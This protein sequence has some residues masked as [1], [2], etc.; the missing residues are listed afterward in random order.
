[1]RALLLTT[2]LCAAPVCAAPGALA[3]SYDDYG[4]AI[5][6]QQLGDARA[7]DAGV[8]GL[9]TGFGP[10]L[11]GSTSGQT[12]KALIDKAPLSS[13]SAVTTD[14]I[15]R[16][17]LTGGTPPQGAVDDPKYMA[18]RLGALVKLGKADEVDLIL[19]RQPQQA[20]SA[21]GRQVSADKALSA[22]DIAGACTIA[23][24][25]TE[26]RGEPY[27]AKLRA[28]CHVTRKEVPA[29]ELT[30][31]LLRRSGH[32]DTDFY[33][34]FDVLTG[35]KGAAFPKNSTEPIILAIGDL[36][37]IGRIFKGAAGD[38]ALAA[39]I[40]DAGDLRPAE[41]AKRLTA[42]TLTKTQDAD[43]AGGFFDINEALKSDTP[44]SWGQLYGVVTTGT[45]AQVNARA[46]GELLRR[47]DA[48]G[49][50]APFAVLLEGPLAA[51]PAY[52]RAQGHVPTFAKLAVMTGDLGALR[53]LYDAAGEDDPIRARLA[54]ASDALGNGF[55]LGQLG[56][57]MTARL[58]A[59]NAAQPRA[60][61]DAFIAAALGARLSEPA[62][63][64]LDEYTG[65]MPGRPAGYGA[66]VT[67]RDAANRG[68]QAETA[69]RAAVIIGKSGP[70][71]LRAD[72][73]A[74]VLSALQTAN[75][76]D[77]AGRLAAE[78]FLSEL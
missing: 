36:T 69:L 14:M 47:A 17:L 7:Y 59:R 8:P 12:A 78:D 24:S 30:V 16:V 65:P 49:I 32:E 70:Q 13:V 39:L 29:A 4:Q 51:M 68:A 20:G 18:A 71:T 43:I 64:V 27:W 5:A 1:M 31:D 73:L 77:F 35:F 3:Q 44:Q 19:G 9:D 10:A 75:L 55:M 34:A 40:K 74:S 53:G 26:A 72:T 54:L 62:M 45:D 76:Q 58:Q 11:W 6:V 22:G 38:A 46:A 56:D 15:A 67:L 37:D 61:R 21:Q 28:V 48:N 41:L 60:V 2:L 25:I 33:A 57:D 63:A 52:L 42:L 66:L 50:L 23:D